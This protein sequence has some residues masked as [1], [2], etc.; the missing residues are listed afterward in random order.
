MQ[1]IGEITALTTAFMWTI[2]G[3][4]FTSAGKRVGSLAV[5]FIRL[6][7]GFIMISI[8]TYFYRGYLLPID[9]TL[10]HWTWL[11]ISGFIGFFL[12][13]LFLFQ[14]YLEL[15]TRITMLIS[16]TGPPITAILGYLFLDEKISAMGLLGMLITISG[17]A[18]VIDRK[19]VV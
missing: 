14:A 11:G 17:I 19:S 18:I 13:D 9:A 10:H 5:N 16:A 7:S 3:V 8:F 1:Y 6:V 12:A 2:M 15:G 4:L